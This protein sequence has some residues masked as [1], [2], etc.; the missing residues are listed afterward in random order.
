MKSM[1]LL[2]SLITLVCASPVPL[3]QHSQ[4]T[5]KGEIYILGGYKDWF[6]GY[7]EN[8]AVLRL[9]RTTDE[10]DTVTSSPA[11]GTRKGQAVLIKNDTVW[12][13]GGSSQKSSGT[14]FF[15]DVWQSTD[16]ISWTKVGT[17]SWSPRSLFGATVFNGKFWI[18]GGYHGTIDPYSDLYSS[19]DGKTWNREI[20]LPTP[21]MSH[22]FTVLQSQ[23]IVLGG[24]TSLFPTD[25]SYKQYRTTG[26]KWDSSTVQWTFPARP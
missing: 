18:G 8:S 25:V 19:S 17:A 1:L 9:N 16:M 12:L 2:L 10:W 15:N 7:A 24:T 13:F 26:A 5:F 14:T 3:A 20:D 23:L 4:I 21:L 22:A 6:D 11:F